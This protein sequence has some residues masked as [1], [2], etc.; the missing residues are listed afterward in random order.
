MWFKMHPWVF[1]IIIG[2]IGILYLIVNIAAI[3]ETKKIQARGSDHHISGIPFLGGIHLL[4]A[5]LISPIKWLALLCVLDFTFWWFLYAIFIDAGFNKSDNTEKLTQGYKPP[6]KHAK[7]LKPVKASGVGI[8]DVLVFLMLL[9]FSIAGYIGGNVIFAYLTGVPAVMLFPYLTLKR[10]YFKADTYGILY[11]KASGFQYGNTSSIKWEQV[12]AIIID[13]HI[14]TIDE[15]LGDISESELNP[16]ALARLD[17]FA[18][19]TP[20]QYED[21]AEWIEDGF[22]IA[23]KQ[24]EKGAPELIE[25][26]S[27]FKQKDVSQKG[28]MIKDLWQNHFNQALKGRNEL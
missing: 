15:K 20:E 18:G 25:V 21:M 24:L 1:P 17:A 23:V 11:R 19:C 3:T 6:K 8:G 22:F 26:G 13:N 14:F 28:E 27:F 16:D 12:D 7:T 4:I 2:S 5:G 10:P 9:V